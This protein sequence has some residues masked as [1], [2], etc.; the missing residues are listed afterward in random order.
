MFPRPAS[1]LKAHRIFHTTAC[2][3]Y[4]NWALISVGHSLPSIFRIQ[5][6]NIPIQ[7][8]SYLVL[9]VH[10]NPRP[11][12]GLKLIIGPDL[13]NSQRP[14]FHP[15]NAQLGCS[16]VQWVGPVTVHYGGVKRIMVLYQH[17]ESNRMEQNKTKVDVSSATSEYLRAEHESL[18][19]RKVSG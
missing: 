15:F 12:L 5:P 4:K 18:T 1:E 2:N 8:G 10:I 6:P 19:L 7:M 14:I 11:D 9:R 16:M 3:H 13:A 17:R